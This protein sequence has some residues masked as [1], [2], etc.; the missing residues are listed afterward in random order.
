MVR[1]RVRA[2]VRGRW[3][4]FLPEAQSKEEGRV[5]CI[6]CVCGFVFSVLPGGVGELCYG[7]CMFVSE[8]Q[9]KS[10]TP[11]PPK[12]YL[13]S[14]LHPGESPE[15]AL[16]LLT[17]LGELVRTQGLEVVG[18]Q[19]ARLRHPEPGTILGKGKVQE[20]L[21]EAKSLG[22][23]VVVTDDVLS[24][25]Q[26]RNWEKM[27]SLAVIDRQ[28]VILDIFAGRAHTRE[29]W[30][31]VQLAKMNYELPRL[32]RKWKHLNRQ[33]GASGGL[34]GR[35]QGEQQLELDARRIRIR[36]QML[37]EELATVRRQREVQR[38]RR[39]V[40]PVPV[41]A[42]VGYTNAGKSSLLH[43]LTQADVLVEDKLFATLDPTV[44]RYL[45]PG[46][47]EVLLADTVGFV[48]KLPHLLIDAFKS[49]LEETRL[50][51]YV[52]ELLDASDPAVLEH[53]DTTMGVLAEIGVGP[54][55]TLLVLNKWD[56]VSE[57]RQ[58]ELLA[59]FPEALPLSVLT[60]EG[61]S[62]LVGRLTELVKAL[63]P[64]RHYLIPHGGQGVVGQIRKYC[65]V[66]AEEY[67]EDGVHLTARVPLNHLERWE[68][69]LCG[70]PPE[71]EGR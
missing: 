16:S 39:L 45:L 38:R 31:Q 29:A 35:M 6:F 58:R 57:E 26:Q 37:R 42:I 49:T 27:S 24:P 40:K 1:A 36:I 3:L 11:V 66:E 48:R 28:E 20:I 62:R 8:S 61:M 5:L 14:F 43:A 41:V 17:E 67:R 19:L 15:E 22:A 71:G 70:A 10:L 51:D 54:K 69:Y 59:A 33:R 68:A 34:G 18:S 60:G 4:A 30:L 50:S 9:D 23:E 47:Q 2:S 7:I 65:F 21:E 44:R 55:P 53:H 13:V 12:A 63:M 52:L 32:V 46:G 64:R 56:L 25:S